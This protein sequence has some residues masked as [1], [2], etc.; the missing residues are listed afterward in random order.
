MKILVLLLYLAL[1]CEDC[2]EFYETGCLQHPLT[3]I[4]DTP[5]PTRSKNFCKESLPSGLT[6]KETT[7]IGAGLGVFAEKNFI[8]GVRFGP[9]KGKTVG[10]LDALSSGYAWEVRYS[11]HT[12]QLFL[13]HAMMALKKV[14]FQSQSCQLGYT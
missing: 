8:K 3:I 11:Q 4:E 1:D 2:Q 5:V 13:K 14:E 12:L 9:Y 6:I 10:E 7:I